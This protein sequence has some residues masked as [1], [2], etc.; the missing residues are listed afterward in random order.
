VTRFE[1]GI[2]L[3]EGGMGRV[4]KVW[5][6]G[7]ERHV[8][9]KVL[10]S[11]DGDAVERMLREARA[12]ARVDH[13]NVARIYD[14]GEL[15]GQPCITMQLVEGRPL[16]EATA[17]LPL[18]RR[19]A[20]MVPVVRAV[21][22]AHAAG[23]VHRDLKPSNVLVEE[24]DDGELVPY[25]VDFGIA[26]EVAG[27][28]ITLSGQI[29]GTPG[30]MSPEQARGEVR[31]SDRRSDVFSLGVLLYELV[32]GEHPFDAG[33]AVATLMRI[34]EEEPPSLAR[35]AP[36]VP[37]DLRVVIERCL[38]KDRERRYPS[39]AALADDLERCLRG[40]PVEARAIGRIERARRRLRRHPL[41]TALVA[42]A[43]LVALLGAGFG[44]AAWR[45]AGEQARAAET[46]GRRVE[47]IE[48]VMRLAHLSPLH[49]LAAERDLV[50]HELDAI[51]AAL[52]AGGRS[53]R[54]PALYAL[55]RGALGLGRPEVAR[56]QFEEAMATGYDAPRVRLALG[57][58]HLALLADALR[59][60]EQLA[61]PGQRQEAR[62][63]AR[64][65]HGARAQELLSATAEEVAEEDGWGRSERELLSG[66]LALAAGDLEAARRHGL[67]AS[68]GLSWLYEG[69]LLAAEADLQE[70]GE[71]LD[72]PPG[73]EI[74]GL[75][76][77]ARSVLEEA[78][79]RA[80]GDPNVHAVLCRAGRLE[81]ER[82]TRRSEGPAPVFERARSSCEAA[83]LAD[84]GHVAALST[85]AHL[86][87]R[88][89]RWL[90]EAGRDPEPHLRVAEESARRLLEVGPS[91]VPSEVGPSGGAGSPILG[92]VHLANAGI[93]RAEWLYDQG[94]SARARGLLREAIG[95]LEEAANRGSDPL[96]YENLG[97]AWYRFGQMSW[98]IGE[99]EAAFGASV[100]AYERGLQIGTGS[101]SD[102]RVGLCVVENEWGYYR[103]QQ[104]MDPGDHLELAAAAC[105]EALAIDPRQ[106][107]ALHYLSMA[108]WGM[109]E[110][111][112]ARGEDPAA[113]LRAAADGFGEVLAHDAGFL[114]AHVNRATVMLQLADQRLASGAEPRDE[115]TELLEEAAAHTEAIREVYPVDHTFHRARL[116]LARARAAVASQR[117]GEAAREFAV[118]RE[119]ARTLA[120][121]WGDRPMNLVHA[122]AVARHEAAW[123]LARGEREQALRLAREARA[124]ADAALA[125]AGE[126]VAGWI[127]KALAAALEADATPDAVA[128]ERVREKARQAARRGQEL[129]L[130]PRG[131]LA[132][133]LE[134]GGG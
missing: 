73:E 60:A 6:P 81:L 59:E 94:G 112:M 84:P 11:D 80:P 61:T 82:A 25:V 102:L 46:F 76:A 27:T 56:Q 24:R 57:R 106:P 28:G 62:E 68:G 63:Q 42:A 21:Q 12:Q 70:A 133:L 51:R 44:L 103:T 29:V 78:G 101:Q 18:D 23:L 7:L 115:F 111:R 26:R 54:G 79:E 119:A 39:A 126:L 9:V 125:L 38:E 75:L 116:H 130:G 97:R 86:A 89:G 108:L 14:V 110:E 36:H 49:D 122:A 2:L 134:E 128:A 132:V 90:V 17:E 48:S 13:P 127:E 69:L 31:A 123:R 30:Y 87:W 113:E 99:E 129:A 85:R 58:A 114:A 15:R 77:R 95:H 67:A 74:A 53:L 107:R 121:R 32:A 66:Q 104:G 55:G 83:L 45:R 93:T 92:L 52:E 91:G 35:I 96:L 118:A 50:E 100:A 1:T 4:L 16:D 43:A 120:E 109:A 22:A 47:R 19:V 34:L 117:E 40:E 37:R 131:E 8:A 88:Y 10:R 33:S 72:G 65:E 64:T 3:G 105:R 41:A 71:L 20:L 5:D 124:R 98:G